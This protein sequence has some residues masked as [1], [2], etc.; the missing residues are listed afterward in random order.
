MAKTQNEKYF[1]D[2]NCSKKETNRTSLLYTNIKMN[3]K[4][5]EDL[6][7]LDVN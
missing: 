5:I 3:K 6:K 1:F 2:C 4:E 7:I